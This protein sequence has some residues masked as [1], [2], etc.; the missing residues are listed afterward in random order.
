MIRP[1]QL[2][3]NEWRLAPLA[4]P[5]LA[6]GFGP[7][8][9][10]LLQILHN[11]GYLKM[12]QIQAFLEGYYL[13]SED[14]FLLPDMDLAVARILRARERGE[15]VVVYG[16]FDADGVTATVLLVE[17]LRAF[18]FERNQAQPYIPDR[19]DEGYGLNDDALTRLRETVG[20][21]L[22]ISVDCGIRSLSEVRHANE[23][24]LDMIIT[25]HHS[26]GTDM[27]EAL[28][29]INPKRLDCQYPER[30]LAGVGIAFKLAQALHQDRPSLTGFDVNSLLDLVAL[31][32]VADLAPLQGE[33]RQ[34]VRRGLE[35]LNSLRRPGVAALARI[36]G[37]KAGHITAETIGFVLGPR[38][39]AA[40]RLSH[41]Y[42]AARLLASPNEPSAERYAHELN[43]LNQR[44]RTLT[45]Q[46]S[47]QAEAMVA[48]GAPILIARGSDFLAGVVGLVASRL[49]EKH[50]RPAIVMEAGDEESRGS[51]R[52][53]PEFHMTNALDEV[54]DLLERHGGHAQAAG[55]TIRNERLPEF[56]ERLTA[57]A[58]EKL[59][60]KDLRPKLDVDAELR[61]PDIDWAL[62]G[63]LEQLEPTGQSNSTPL[64]MSR[65]LHVYNHRAVGQD[66]AHLKV[67]LGDG[68]RK[69]QGIAFRQGAWS[70]AMPER[71][72]LVY[73]LNSNE[74][75]G[76]RN[77][78][79]M[80]QDIRPAEEEK[81]T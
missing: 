32:T 10:V 18:G 76:N 61:L 12:S 25:D 35:V 5:E 28:A 39:N 71:V 33:N 6:Q 41:A 30:M 9:P 38:L 17:A 59:R 4:P 24:G 2:R 69:F 45:K 53:I 3:E 66:G 68:W 75:N 31:G 1:P 47:D 14:P 67:E 42:D 8:H 63:V 15:R 74:W 19:V 72:D 80:I 62:F 54:A 70:A 23:I 55:F 64:F 43:R 11:R 57:I 27:P 73:Q 40:G 49:A 79:L 44:R 46:L 52:S 36:A 65:N 37:V 81:P 22:V 29:V 16:D 60:D 20:A 56:T 78:E 51:C 34:L 7:L 58:E 13:E 77:L 26:L 48:D 21:D 50:Y